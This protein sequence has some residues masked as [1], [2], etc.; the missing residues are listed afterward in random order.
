MIA[1]LKPVSTVP[2]DSFIFTASKGKS[3]KGRVSELS[4]PIPCRIRLFE[5]SSGKLIADV[6]TDK[7]GN[8]EFDHLTQIKCFIVAHHPTS[9]FNAVIQDNVVPK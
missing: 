8:Y 6:S 7:F 4:V 2:S 1:D 9:K 3:I 5:K